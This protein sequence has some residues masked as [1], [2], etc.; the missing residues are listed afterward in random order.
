MYKRQEDRLTTQRYFENVEI[1]LTLTDGTVI[2]LS[3]AGGSIGP[4]DGVTVCSKGEVFSEVLPRED[5]ASISAVSYTHLGQRY[6]PVERVGICVPGS[7]VAFPSTISVSYTHLDVYKRQF[8]GTFIQ[9]AA[10]EFVE[11]AG[12]AGF[13]FLTVDQM[14]IRDRYLSYLRAH[15]G[16]AAVWLVGERDMPGLAFLLR[17][18]EPDREALSAACALARESGVSEALALLLEQQRDVA[19]RGLDKTFDL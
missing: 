15:A 9:S 3:N 19:P 10:P 11:A 8:L 4:E 12:Y 18:A 13:R 17:T 16:E 6:T 2:D 1:L 7:P 14:C 5:M